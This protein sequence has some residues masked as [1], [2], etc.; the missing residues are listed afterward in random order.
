MDEKKSDSALVIGAGIAGIKASLDLAEQG[1]RVTLCD[2][3]AYAGGALLQLDQWFPDDHCG[4][5]KVLPVFSRDAVSQYCLRRGLVHPNITVLGGADVVKVDG[6]AGR[7]TATLKTASA[8]IKADLCIGCGK[9][10]EVCPVEAAAEFNRGMTKRKAAYLPNPLSLSKT[11]RIDPRICTRCGA[12]AEVCPTRAVDLSRQD[13]EQP[14]A[15][16]AIILA[17]GFEEFDAAAASQYGYGRFPNVITGLDLERMLSGSGPTG[18]ELVRPSDHQRPKSVAFLQCVGSRTLSRHYCSSA[19]CMIALKE[20]MMVKKA[21]PDADVCIFFMDLRAFGKGYHRYYDKA[22]DEMGIRFI[23]CRVPRV[24]QNFKTK[25]VAFHSVSDQSGIINEN[26]D[27]VVLSAGQ[28]PSGH[29]GTVADRLGLELTPSGFCRTGSFSPVESNRA[30]I[31]VCGTASGPKDIA[32][33]LTEASAAAAQAALL[34]S[35]APEPDIGAPVSEAGDDAKT[36]VIVCNCGGEIGNVID[37]GELTAFGRD[38]PGVV[39][40]AEISVLCRE[41]VLEKTREDI[42]R[43]GAGRVIVAGCPAPGPQNLFG[44]R[45][46]E[47]VN[48]RE[49]L[50]WVHR[51][52]PAQALRK[53]KAMLAMAASK[54]RLAA[55]SVPSVPSPVKPG[56]LV[57]GGG[58]AGL[59]SALLIAGRGH[60]VDLVE[61]TGDLGGNLRQ[62]SATLEGA[63]V[64]ALLQNLVQ[65]VAETRQITLWKETE[66]EK[67]TGHAGDFRITLK[68]M[69][70]QPR[71]IGAGAVVI[72]AGAEASKPAEYLYG[73]DESVI[74]QRE[75][76]EQIHGGRIDPG[77]LRS[78]TMIQCVGSRNAERPYCSRICCAEALKNALRLKRDNPAL[79]ITV[80]YRD[81]MSYG[82]M[83]EYYTLAREKGV[84]FARYD[85]DHLPEVSRVEGLLTVKTPDAVLGQT[86][87]LTPDLLVLSTAVV[88]V[89][90]AALAEAIDT[91]LTEDGFFREAEA[92]FRPVDL[93][94]DGIF[95][96]GLAHSP[97]NIPETIVQAAAAAGRASL[98]LGKSSLAS[99]RSVSAVNET[100]CSACELCVSAC[101]YGARMMNPVKN[102]AMVIE[103]L[104]QGCGACVS[105]CPNKAA[106]LSD[107][108]D[109]QIFAALD[110]AM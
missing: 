87:E 50:A 3:K 19:C 94:R 98:I 80:L 77:K 37:T 47:I 43:A 24:M 88:P 102:A 79:A 35:P 36:A 96:C 9:C 92:K 38:L 69:D 53:A 101:P 99:G 74:T 48:I 76:E 64:Q 40:A 85:L 30:G 66:V 10:A 108:S 12:C 2:R 67:I 106:M 4:M 7:F 107:R 65:R 63:D 41:D 86:L 90:A 44:H 109:R 20:A 93:I 59:T 46:T 104:C 62:I 45:P 91:E 61:K 29:L 27:L 14:F 78:L 6:K 60:G 16:G 97:R 71:E 26:F 8:G 82:F 51:E 73:R 33:S 22:R 17:T 68:G 1:F 58:L 31:F 39:H 21:Y 55:P 18:G 95:V 72:A 34:L 57:I 54:M 81:L 56:A 13:E 5:C 83:E 89:G 15:A 32:E 23:R 105:A 103:A 25:E 28:S 49:G 110:A 42:A 11:Y 75:L 84:I 100:W 70:S 52:Q